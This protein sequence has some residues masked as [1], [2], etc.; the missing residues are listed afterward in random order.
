MYVQLIDV[1]T[2]AERLGI[3]RAMLYLIMERGE[4]PF[5]KIGTRRLIDE[6]DLAAFV[7]RRRSAP[8]LEIAALR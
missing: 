4:L 8:R 5:E 1:K 6:S 7:N 3:S 2:A